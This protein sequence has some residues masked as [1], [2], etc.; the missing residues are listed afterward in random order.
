M[1]EQ[2]I[3]QIGPEAL[4]S[5]RRI[6]LAHQRAA[7]AQ[8][9][10]ADHQRPH[11]QHIALISLGDA[12]VDDKRHD[13]RQEKFQHRLQQLEKRSCDTFLAEGLEKAHKLKHADITPNV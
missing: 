12:V 13:S 10:H 2:G 1:L 11:L 6:M 8:N 7:I 4:G 5:P 3:A 9:G